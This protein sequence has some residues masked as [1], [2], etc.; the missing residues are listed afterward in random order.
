MVPTA[1]RFGLV[2][3][4]GGAA[5]VVT[6]GLFLISAIN[7]IRNCPREARTWVSLL[8]LDWLHLPVMSA[9][10]ILVYSDD[11]SVRASVISALGRKVAV[12]LPSHEI[13]EFATADALRLYVD[14]KKPVS[15][16]I[17]DGEAVPEGG[18][19]IARALKDEVYQC[20]PVLLITGRVADAWLASWSRAEEVV[21]HPIDPFTLAHKVSELL[22]KQLTIVN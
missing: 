19:G 11:Q 2:T 17:L 1:N 22:R 20:P 21:I 9:P 15:L 16:F 18:M 12:D 13:I 4:E 6:G 3:F 8:T 14:A 10:T 7:R 5:N